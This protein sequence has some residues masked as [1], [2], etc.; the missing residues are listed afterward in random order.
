M[1]IYRLKTAFQNR[2]RP[3]SNTLVKQGFTAN[4]VTISAVIL[5]LVIAHLIAQRAHHHRTYWHLLPTGLFVRMAMNAIDGMMA[6]EHGQAS[7][8]GAWLNET[9]DMLSDTVLFISLLG[10]TT[11]RGHLIS[12]TALSL[13]TELTAVMA[14]L[15]TGARANHGP[16]GKSDR[17]LALGILGVMMGLDKKPKHERLILVIGQALLIQTIINRGCYIIKHRQ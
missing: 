16:L 2:L 10:H 12:A 3:I 1:S 11:H 7:T 4:R 17:A 15:Q 5:S 6:R 9:G 13:V 14:T 8:L